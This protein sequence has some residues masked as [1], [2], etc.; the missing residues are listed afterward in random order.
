MVNDGMNGRRWSD[1]VILSMSQQIGKING[2]I[3]GIERASNET[4]EDV[5]EIL[6]NI[7]VIP[8][9]QRMII[10]HDKRIGELEQKSVVYESAVSKIEEHLKADE[11]TER[12]IDRSIASW[13]KKGLWVAMTG[14]VGWLVAKMTGK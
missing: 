10:Q 6:K 14:L 1:S 3:E 5:K 7:A 2:Q 11:P 13:V 4:R 12:Y 9:M 8:E